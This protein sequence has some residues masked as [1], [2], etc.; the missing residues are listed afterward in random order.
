MITCTYLI[1][2]DFSIP[3]VP[4]DGY[5]LDE[6]GV[7]D[8]SQKQALNTLIRTLETETHHQIGVAIVQNLQGR[9]VEEFSL[10]L[11]RTW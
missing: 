5:I 11:A 2:A 3:S 8:V 9:P 4:K 7:L 1:F 6:V 10:N